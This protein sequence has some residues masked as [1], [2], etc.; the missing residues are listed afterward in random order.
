MGS[1]VTASAQAPT[2]ATAAA[3]DCSRDG[4]IVGDYERLGP[5]S[6]SGN[7]RIATASRQTQCARSIL[8]FSAICIH[9]GCCLAAKG[10][11]FRAGKRRVLHLSDSGRGLLVGMGSVVTELPHGS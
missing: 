9:I 5:T 2:S 8:W 1:A 10:Q 11:V 7:S 6:T 4:L 3:M